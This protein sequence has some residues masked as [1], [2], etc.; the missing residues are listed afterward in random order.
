MNEPM[1]F[2]EQTETNERL[3]NVCDVN[4]D[5]IKPSDNI[6]N[7]G[8]HKTS[9]TMRSTTSSA[10]L[11]AEAELA[12]LAT[13]QML[14]DE[15]HALEEEELCKKKARLQLEEARLQLEE[16]EEQLCK[17]K[18]KLQLDTEIA[19]KMAKLNILKTRSTTSGKRSSKV[20]DGMNSYLEKGKSQQ[21]LNVNAEEF[22]PS[23]TAKQR[24]INKDEKQSIKHTVM[25]NITLS[26]NKVPQCSVSE[27]EPVNTQYFP[28]QLTSNSNPNAP[29][30][31]NNEDIL[32]IMRKQNEITTLLI[33]QQCLTALPKREVPIFDGDPLT[34]HTFLKAFENGVERNTTN[35]SDRLYFLEQ[36]TKGH[37]KELVRSCQYINSDHGYWR[38][39]TLLKEQFGN[40]Q[41]VAFCYMD[42]ALS[43]PTI[44]T[45]DVKALQDYGLFLRGC[46]NAMEDVQYLHDLDVPSNMLNI[47]MKLPYKFRDKWRSQACELQERQQRRA[48]FSDSNRSCLRQHSRFT[49][50]NKSR[51]I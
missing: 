21:Q 44:K 6:S 45:E 32:G 1:C 48:K 25:K 22:H 10:C 36:H 15:K 39:K 34:Y 24:T 43:W 29:D 4:E 13:R 47:I 27:K 19:E 37:A 40:E 42:K 28:Q 5:D 2:V 11:M 51:N 16:E 8:S 49:Y 12:A 18:E 14:L 17:R 26:D 23:A 41:K 30:V 35:N 31:E 9:R 38:A 7:V 33:Q 50:N 46:C 20:S 3:S